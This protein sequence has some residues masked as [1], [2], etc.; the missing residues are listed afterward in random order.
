[1]FKG[2]WVSGEV[3]Q[4]EKGTVSLGER[5]SEDKGRRCGEGTI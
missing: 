3:T 4:T 5:T 1:M 2:Y